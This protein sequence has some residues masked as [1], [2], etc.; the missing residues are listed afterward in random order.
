MRS[1]LGLDIGGAN[2]KAAHTSG[3]AMTVPFALWKQP[4]LLT[5]KLGQLFRQMPANDMVAVTM[6][7]ELC[8]CYANRK[9]GVH[10]ILDAVEGASCG[11]RPLVWQTTGKFTDI[12]GARARWEKT[13]SA[14]WLATA[15]FARRYSN[16]RGNAYALLLDMGSTT[17]DL[18]LLNAERT[19]LFGKTDGQRLALGSL[20][21]TGVTRSPVYALLH[22]HAATLA[23]HQLALI[24]E[25]F[26]TTKDVY[27]QLDD[28]PED[29]SD[30]DT[31]DGKPRTKFH[32]QRRLMRV[33][34]M[35]DSIEAN[36]ADANLL[37][38]LAKSSQLRQITD[39]ILRFQRHC[40]SDR[41]EYVITGSGEFL[42]RQALHQFDDRCQIVSLSEKLGARLSTAAAAYS[43]AV[44]AA[45]RGD[46][47][48]HEPI[49][50]VKVGGSLFGLPD[51]GDKLG[52]WL[53]SLPTRR[54]LLI[55]G[56]GPPADY[57]RSQ[58]R[59]HHFGDE[60]AHQLA[61]AAMDFQAKLLEQL[62]PGSVVIHELADAAGQWNGDKYLILKISPPLLRMSS[63]SF[64]ALPESWSA[65]SDSIAA[66]VAIDLE[67][68]HLVLLKSRRAQSGLTW[69]EHAADGLVDQCFPKLA[70]RV[71]SIEVVD[72]RSPT[73]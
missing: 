26:A 42:L 63:P 70:V 44:L 59:L 54:V 62:L 72:L 65:T 5:D 58:Q 52:R 19:L 51:L 56:G 16:S 35:D 11:L 29:A 40:D 1:V 68:N 12:P 34:G 45:E 9:E 20:I 48:L 41:P 55:P 66:A 60:T 71:P 30:S 61:L 17:F 3:A 64:C 4:E 39:G 50:V 38:R 57:I 53:R 67:A 25:W 69:E 7:G 46:V 6:T 24:P 8:D 32:A 49:Y 36:W 14:N 73:A 23:R 18:T 31:A 21:Y 47:P 33:V 43:V 37:A 13:A 22:E 15:E 27:T 28:L 10:R 2:L